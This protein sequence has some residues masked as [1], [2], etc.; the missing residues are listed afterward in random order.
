MFFGNY[1][2]SIDNKGRLVIPARFRLA[3]N[4]ALFA[5]RGYEKCLS[6]YPSSAFEALQA[7]LEKLNFT[8][9]AARDYMRITLASTFELTIDDHGRIQIP[10]ATAK[11]YR[12]DGA[13]RLIGV[14]DHIEVWSEEAWRAYQAEADASYEAT[15]ETLKGS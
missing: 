14:K 3:V 12:L 9:K 1:V 13:V 15:A 7:D 11:E 2:Y 4:D 10:A 8:Q 6:L 5:M